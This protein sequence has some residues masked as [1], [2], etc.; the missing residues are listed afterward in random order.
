MTHC[1]TWHLETINQPEHFEWYCFSKHNFMSHTCIHIYD[2]IYT[3][4]EYFIF[5]SLR[6][7]RMY[8]II[9]VLFFPQYSVSTLYLHCYVQLYYIHFHCSII[10][11]VWLFPHI[12]YSCLLLSC[13][14]DD[15]HFLLMQAMLQ[16]AFC[17]STDCIC[18][19][20]CVKV[21]LGHRFSNF[22]P[23]DLNLLRCAREI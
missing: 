10:S 17:I 7:I 2:D 11:I 15:L 5:T 21:S 9:W 16:G 12:I 23:E 20:T 8:V 6:Y 14:L 13:Y 22:W 3:I 1:P 18:W 19:S 4:S